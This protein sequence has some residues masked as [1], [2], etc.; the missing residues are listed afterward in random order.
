MAGS[1]PKVRRQHNRK[2]IQSLKLKS[3]IRSLR[4]QRKAA[5]RILEKTGREIE[6]I[7][8]GLAALA[9]RAGRVGRPQG[10]RKRRKMSAEAR[11]RISAAQK[12]RWRELRAK[13]K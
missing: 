4:S 5:T 7:D 3:I 8:A 2:E 1:G 10:V 9:G 12:R 13:A 6:R 11:A